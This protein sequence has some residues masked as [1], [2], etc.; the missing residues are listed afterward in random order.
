M[1]RIMFATKKPDEVTNSS[2][3]DEDDGD[4]MSFSPYETHLQQQTLPSNDD[5][6]ASAPSTCA[7][8][9]AVAIGA[10]MAGRPTESVRH[11]RAH[12]GNFTLETLFAELSA[13]AC[14]CVREFFLCAR[15]KAPRCTFRRQP[16]HKRVSTS[17]YTICIQGPFRGFYWRTWTWGVIWRL[18]ISTA[19][20]YLALLLLLRLW[21]FYT[22][23]D[24]W[25]A[26]YS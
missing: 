10:L 7:F 24:R 12:I 17:F 22:K 21:I 5:C 15:E 3:H 8:W 9:S 19:T 11:A 2:T 26:M 1:V 25:R 20:N 6:S 14:W 18:N 23:C 13:I 4:N 16:F